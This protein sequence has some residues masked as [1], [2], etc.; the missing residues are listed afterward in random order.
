MNENELIKKIE[1]GLKLKI[2]NKP[3]FRKY[4]SESILLNKK[5]TFYDF[6][7][8]P[9]K[10]IYIDGKEYIDYQM[11]LNEIFSGKKDDS[12]T[13]LPKAVEYRD[14]E[15]KILKSLQK[16]GINFRYVK[17]IAD[18]NLSYI[19]PESLAITSKQQ[20][21]SRFRLF[22]LLIEKA[23]QNYPVKCEV[24]LFSEL[25]KPFQKDYDESFDIAMKML[26][27]KR[28]VDTGTLNSQILRTK[29][30]VG[31]ANVEFADLFS[32]RTIATYAAEGIIFNLLSYTNYFSN[33]VWLNLYEFNKRTEKITNCLRGQKGIKKIPMLTET[34]YSKKPCK[35]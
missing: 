20:N 12:F 31:I 18:T 3:L 21:A 13:E 8:P 34:V 35:S 33:C 22:K 4:L 11:D 30:H 29:Q 27:L 23:V 15:I 25:I 28:L 26:S 24:V 7:C 9:R 10:V 5:I 32:K 16:L 19:T 6:E 14:Q 17:I 1:S 2:I